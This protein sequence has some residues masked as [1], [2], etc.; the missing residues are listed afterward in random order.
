MLLADDSYWDQNAF[1]DLVRRGM[2]V[3]KREDRLFRWVVDFWFSTTCQP[4]WETG[5]CLLKGVLCEAQAHICAS[6][7]LST[8]QV[9]GFGCLRTQLGPLASKAALLARQFQ[10][11]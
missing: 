8:R 4:A 1:N 9:V 2:D 10:E 11:G 3:T 6:S 5:R 7:G